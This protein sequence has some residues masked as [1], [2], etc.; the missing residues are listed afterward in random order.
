[1]SRARVNIAVN[2]VLEQYAMYS[3]EICGAIA[4]ELLQEAQLNARTAYD[5]RTRNLT[6]SIQ[7]RKSK[8]NKG[9]FIVGAMASGGAKG[10]HAHLV[11]QGHQMVVKDGRVVGHVPPY[12]FLGPA[13]QDVR[14]R[15]P[16]II[17][18][19]GAPTVVVKS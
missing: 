5:D 16:E 2:A 4:D 9:G 1:M 15:I 17:K 8:Y 18:R 10:Y 3:G 13:E 14:A 6:N 11:E 19:V 12:P 7:K